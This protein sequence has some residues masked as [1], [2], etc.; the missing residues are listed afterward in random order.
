MPTSCPLDR[1]AEVAT[2]VLCF[3]GDSEQH[4][5]R[6]DGV[7]RAPGRVAASWSRLAQRD[8]GASDDC[9]RVGVAELASEYS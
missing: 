5:L 2:A 6:R 7:E 9:A 1:R 3:A 4:E 8:A